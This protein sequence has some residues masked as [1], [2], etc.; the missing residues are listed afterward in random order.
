MGSKA[1]IFAV[2]IVAFLALSCSSGPKSVKFNELESR[3]FTLT[4]VFFMTNTDTYDINDRSLFAK[5]PINEVIRY[6]ESK[7][8]INIDRSL[9]NSNREMKSYSNIMPNRFIEL[10]TENTQRISIQ[11]HRFYQ[12]N[13]LKVFISLRIFKNGERIAQT[14]IALS[15]EEVKN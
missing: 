1:F 7:Y 13:D 8:E 6:I 9:L 11:F 14:E 12:E 15:G 10:D 4:R 2:S 3:D 5:L